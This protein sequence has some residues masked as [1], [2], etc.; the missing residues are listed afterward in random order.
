M[1]ARGNKTLLRLPVWQDVPLLLEWEQNPEIIRN[2]RSNAPDFDEQQLTD[3]VVHKNDFS[4]YGQLRLM[5]VNH[6]GRA[7]GTLD[8]FNFR[9]DAGSCEIGIL[10]ADLRERNQGYGADALAAIIGYA[11]QVLC[12]KTLIA[13]VDLF[14]RPSTRLF[15]K[16]GYTGVKSSEDVIQFTLSLANV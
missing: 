11:R 7:I 12:L 6:H 1:I 14:N 3:F 16:C 9:A 10:I 5:I 8:F 13:H 15:E 2:G 4:L